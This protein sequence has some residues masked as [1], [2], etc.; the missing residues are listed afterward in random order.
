MQIESNAENAFTIS[1]SG[2]ARVGFH[3]TSRAAI[4]QIETNG[5]LPSKVLSMNQ[6]RDLLM[7]ADEL[8]IPVWTYKSWLG[9]RSV[10]FTREFETAKEHIE[11]RF[12]S[13]QGVQ[14]MLAVA[15]LVESKGHEQH[16]MLAKRVIDQ[17][18]E[19]QSSAPIIYAVDLSG[20]DRLVTDDRQPLFYFYWDPG[21][22]LPLLSEIGPSRLI[23]RLDII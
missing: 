20:L 3:A 23:G 5:F 14:Q 8:G 6:H 1:F 19:F 21:Q 7:A 13:G 17:I 2:V 9:L 16:G 4:Q 12:A 15:K 10:T 11:R 18:V 22:P